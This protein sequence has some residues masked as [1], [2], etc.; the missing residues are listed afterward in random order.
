MEKF[1]DALPMDRYE[2]DMI[3]RW[4]SRRGGDAGSYISAI[5]KEKFLV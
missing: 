1:A 2:Y 5:E 4:T 3:R